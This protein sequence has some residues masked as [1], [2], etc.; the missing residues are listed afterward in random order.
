MEFVVESGE[1]FNASKIENFIQRTVISFG[2]QLHCISSRLDW[3][4]PKQKRHENWWHFINTAQLLLTVFLGWFKVK[5][6]HEFL[7]QNSEFQRNFWYFKLFWQINP[8]KWNK[9]HYFLFGEN[10]S[11]SVKFGIRERMWW[12]THNPQSSL[13][14]EKFVSNNVTVFVWMLKC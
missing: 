9:I 4:Y 5:F 11:E 10:I 6:F 3:K 2:S 13:F 8:R 14:F 12:S 1:Q 7:L